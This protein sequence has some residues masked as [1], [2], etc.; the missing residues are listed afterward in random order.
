[1]E[2]AYL[3]LEDGT[4][5]TGKGFGSSK[6]AVC[7]VV[8]NTSMAGY[9]EVITDPSYA[10]QGVVMT[11]PLIGNY[12]MCAS[13]CESDRPWISA[14]IVRELSTLASNFRHNTSLDMYLNYHQIPGIQWLDTRAL[15][16]RLR[17]NGTMNGLI[18]RDYT[19]TQ[20]DKLQENLEKIQKYYV[21]GVVAKVSNQTDDYTEGD[22]PK[23]AI[24]DLGSKKSIPDRLIMRGLRVQLY[25]YDTP[26]EVILKDE[27]DGVM[28]T[29]GPGDP[30]DCLTT[31]ENVRILA[32]KGPPMMAICL[33]HQ[34]LALSLGGT[35]R[36]MKWGHRGGNHP[37]KDLHTGRVAITSQNH[38]YVV[39]TFD[40]DSTEIS[41]INVN[42][43][44]IEGLR[45]K[46]K[47]IIS[48]QFHPEAACGPTDCDSL[49]DDFMD[50][51]RKYRKQKFAK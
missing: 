13:D 11:Y 19:N 17:T 46:G 21:N 7:E 47:N 50:M 20:G 38:G 6:D 4:I 25:R 35:T 1:M 2:K 3:I 30:A 44:S 39:D 32:T 18:T 33:G 12:G 34:I 48:V 22:G 26:A 40:H 45:Y 10:G 37:V 51:I 16:R 14:L 15:T 8:F 36:K 49:F 31:I 24:L 5:M 29:N 27:P 28:L 42:D 41:H 43:Q 9:V 23:I